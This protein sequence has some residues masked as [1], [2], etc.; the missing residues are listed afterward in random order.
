MS[1][2]N[3]QLLAR[4]EVIEQWINTLQT[5]ANNT[6]TRREMKNLFALITSQISSLQDVIG[7]VDST[8]AL[9][10]PRVTTTER[11]ALTVT[12]GA[13]VFNLTTSK[14]NTYNGSSWEVVTSS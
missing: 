10:P 6:A 3:D 8:G 5:S 13:V 11:D 2:T 4:I 1:L 9:Y 7:T 14:L 12:A